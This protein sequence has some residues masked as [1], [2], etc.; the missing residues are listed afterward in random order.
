MSCERPSCYCSS[1]ATVHRHGKDY[2]SEHCANAPAGK[3]CR[4]AHLGCSGSEEVALAEG[5]ALVEE[6]SR[7]I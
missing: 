3:T 7:S 1:E 5:R 2:C 6:G 4:C